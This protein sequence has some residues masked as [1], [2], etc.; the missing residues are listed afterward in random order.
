MTV[1]RQLEFW[2]RGVVLLIWVHPAFGQVSS[3]SAM[4]KITVLDDRGATVESDTHVRVAGRDFDYTSVVRR[5]GSLTLPYGTYTVTAWSGGLVG[6]D[7][8][9]QIHQPRADLVLVLS[10]KPMDDD[11][12]WIIRGKIVPA[13]RRGEVMIARLIGLYFDAVYDTVVDEDGGFTIEA[14]RI[15]RYKLWILSA[16]RRVAERDVEVTF[17]PKDLP[18]EIRLPR[19]NSPK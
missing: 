1:N 13:P 19:T 7:R 11:L 17:L 5:S 3:R 2:A 10:P 15:S 9:V 4:I 12:P 16:G 8:L 14:W 18:I 6:P